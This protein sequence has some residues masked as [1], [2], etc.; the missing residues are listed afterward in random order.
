MIGWDLGVGSLMLNTP[1]QISTDPDEQNDPCVYI[2]A[3]IWIKPHTVLNNMAIDTQTMSIIYHEGLQLTIN[4]RLWMSATVG[5]VTMPGS[6]GIGTSFFYRS[7]DASFG[8]GSVI[9][10]YCLFNSLS[11]GTRSGNIDVNIVP[12]AQLG[13]DVEH[14]F[15]NLKSVNGD[16]KAKTLDLHDIQLGPLPQSNPYRAFH[17]TVST[18]SGK[19]EVQLIHGNSTSLN[20][21]SGSIN[22]ILIPFDNMPQASE[23]TVTNAGGDNNITVTPSIFQSQSPIKRLYGFFTSYT[24]NMCITFPTTWE[25]KLRGQTLSG[26][27]WI[28]WSSLSIISDSKPQGPYWRRLIAVKGSGEGEISFQETSGSMELRDGSVR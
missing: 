20:S 19:I 2:N 28:D 7:L 23:I 21:M 27:V 17:S 16:I 4:N 6:N 22:A 3:T 8:S 5:S 12:R 11:I 26:G 25:G 18:S 24:G 15:L 10:T 9:G 1:K 14:S 13:D